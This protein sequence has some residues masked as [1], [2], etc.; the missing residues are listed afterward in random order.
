MGVIRNI[1][2]RRIQRLEKKKGIVEERL[3][4]VRALDEASA[5]F[6]KPDAEVSKKMQKVR[7]DRQ[8][9]DLDDIEK[10]VLWDKRIKELKAK[11][12]K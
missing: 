1:R 8:L 12:Q 10:L 4:E 6:E 7:L 3:N 9:G 5:M 11:Q 2:G